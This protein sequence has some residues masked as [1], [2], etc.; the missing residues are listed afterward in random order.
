MLFL[1]PLP[2]LLDDLG[3]DDLLDPL[4]LLLLLV[5]PV[6]LRHVLWEAP[7]TP[8]PLEDIGDLEALPR[9]GGHPHLGLLLEQGAHPSFFLNKKSAYVMALTLAWKGIALSSLAQ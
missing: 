5:A 9:L 8:H 3:L 2:I 7:R 1:L 4:A 6:R